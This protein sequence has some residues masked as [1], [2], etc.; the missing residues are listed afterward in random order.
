MSYTSFV[1]IVSGNLEIPLDISE[2]SKIA[3]LQNGDVSDLPRLFAIT[4]VLNDSLQNLFDI[5]N[6]I[7]IEN[8]NYNSN[9]NTTTINLNNNSLVSGTYNFIFD[10][11]SFVDNSPSSFN[12]KYT[13]LNV[14]ARKLSGKLNI[15]DVENPQKETIKTTQW[16]SPNNN[17]DVDYNEY[18]NYESTEDIPDG[19]TNISSLAVNV[20]NSNTIKDIGEEKEEYIELIL[21]QIY[22]LPF[23]NEHKILREIVTN[24]ICAEL[25]NINYS[26]LNEDTELEKKYFIDA[27]NKL[28]LL[29]SGYN[30]ELP[31]STKANYDKFYRNR[32]TVKRIKLPGEILIKQTQE[33]QITNFH[34]SIDRF[35]DI[36][37]KTFPFE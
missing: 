4:D 34:L 28:Q 6:Y 25:L 23:K 1:N 35:E 9:N 31:Y 21:G 2:N 30:I 26:V 13:N 3:V 11:P 14:I 29:I 16:I 19:E 8:V 15:I 17:D 37:D 24:L 22:E 27:T 32:N 20:V 36:P 12:L 7:L 33:N 10:E 18:L 5:N